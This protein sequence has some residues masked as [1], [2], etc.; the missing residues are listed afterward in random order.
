[1]SLGPDQAEGFRVAISNAV[2]RR[3]SHRTQWAAQFAVASELC[4]RGYEV[5][6]TMG[7]H[8]AVDLMARSPTRQISFQ[9]DVKGLYKPNFWVIKPKPPNPTLFYVLAFVPNDAQNRFFVLAQDEVN[10]EIE[11]ELQRA[12]HRAAVKGRPLEKAELFAGV[13]QKFAQGFENRWG[14]LPL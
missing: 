13:G 4:K 1:M 2:E 12:R 3:S 5:A 10:A 8:P 7:N 9:I 14:I 11:A 6:F